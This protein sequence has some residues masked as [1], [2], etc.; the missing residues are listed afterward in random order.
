[1]FICMQLCQ[2]VSFF[3]ETL[4]FCVAFRALFLFD[5]FVVDFHF[6]ESFDENLCRKYSYFCV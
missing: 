4:C 1:M 6:Y 2:N 5:V 3:F